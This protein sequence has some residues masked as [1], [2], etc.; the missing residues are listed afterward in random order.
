MAYMPG[1][2]RRKKALSPYFMGPQIAPVFDLIFT[3]SF[4]KLSISLVSP[5]LYIIELWNVGT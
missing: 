5:S 4:F 3:P 2:K 1:E